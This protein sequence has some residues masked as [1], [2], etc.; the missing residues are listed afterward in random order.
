MA[1]LWLHRSLI[2]QFLWREIRNRY[3]GSRFSMCWSL[4]NPVLMLLIYTFVFSFVLKVRWGLSLQE[5]PLEFA[6]TLYCGLLVFHMFS[7]SIGRAPGLIVSHPNYVKK[8]VFPL[9]VLPVTAVANAVVSSLLGLVIVWL[10]SAC[11]VRP[12]GWQA[13]LLP[14]FL[15]PYL[16]LLLGLSWFLAALGCFLRDLGPTIGVITQLLIFATPVFYP[17]SAVPAEWRVFL[18]LN[19]L[20]IFVEN[21]RR[22]LLWNLEPT[23]LSWAAA[24]LLS[25]AVMQ[26]GYMC[27]M[28]SKRAFADVV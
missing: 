5:T 27:F 15:L 23:W 26:A 25:L 12:P 7:E 8:V 10:A 24:S 9:E 2:R 14:L 13:L 3:Q 28:R 1:T 21:S 18:Q 17:L 6:L 4:A 22:L 19:P 20:A 16:G 11:L